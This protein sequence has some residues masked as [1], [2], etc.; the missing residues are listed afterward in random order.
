MKT[1]P[2]HGH[3][4]W[5]AKQISNNCRCVCDTQRVKT[6]FISLKKSPEN[7]GWQNITPRGLGTFGVKKTCFGRVFK[8]TA[9]LSLSIVDF[10]PFIFPFNNNIFSIALHW[11]CLKKEVLGVNSQ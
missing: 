4:V 9:D 2:R 1:N 6:H 10:F 5:A 3:W 11:K 8:M 7:D